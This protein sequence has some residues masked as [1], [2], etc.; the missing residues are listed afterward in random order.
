VA[1]VLLLASM[2]M[3]SPAPGRMDRV[4]PLSQ[5]ISMAGSGWSRTPVT[6]PAVAESEVGE[7]VVGEDQL[8]SVSGG[9]VIARL[10]HG[11]PALRLGG[12]PGDDSQSTQ[13]M[14][15]WSRWS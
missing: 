7:G 9:N 15:V 10:L 5:S 12:V 3:R 8:H 11:T 6:V 2:R 4:L 14:V 13:R 1:A